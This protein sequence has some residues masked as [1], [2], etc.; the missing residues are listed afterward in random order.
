VFEKQG[1]VDEAI[2]EV[3]F[4]GPIV[5]STSCPA[6]VLGPGETATLSIQAVCSDPGAFEEDASLRDSQGNW[7]VPVFGRCL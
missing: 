2:Y 5:C 6:G 1:T 3:L 4:T 7:V